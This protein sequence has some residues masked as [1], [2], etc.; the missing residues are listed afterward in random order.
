MTNDTAPVAPLLPDVEMHLYKPNAPATARIVRS[1]ICTASRKAAGIVRH[2]EFD[3]SGTDLEGR[4]K[5][6]QSIGIIAPGED[7]KGRP[8]R[9]RLYSLASPTKGEDGNGAILSTTVK[10]TVDEHWE[11]HT[12]FLGV[13]SNYLCDLAEGAE[14]QVTGPAGK[15]FILPEDPSAHDYVFVATGTGIAPFRGMVRDL[16]DAGCESQVALLMGAPYE[17]D[18]LYHDEFTGL[19]SGYEQFTYHTALSRQPQPDGGDRM[20]VHKRLGADRERLGPMLESERTLVY[21]CGIAGMEIGLLQ[22]MARIM[23]GSSLEQYLHATPEALA[24]I[25]GWN[26]KMLHR[27]IKTTKRVMLEVYA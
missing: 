17:T 20:Y 25:D 5:P 13:A 12:L 11:D 4:C 22:E 18:L 9:V 23:P 27:E 2:I 19:A 8:H 14:I 3:V 24:D 16:I 6:G 15:R 7:A 26:R 10:R 1:E 21:V